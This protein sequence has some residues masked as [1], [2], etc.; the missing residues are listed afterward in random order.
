MSDG[1]LSSGTR[2]GGQGCILCDCLLLL[3]VPGVL[4]ASFSFRD[5][6]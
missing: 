4:G 3:H 5:S 1:L 6:G 2:T